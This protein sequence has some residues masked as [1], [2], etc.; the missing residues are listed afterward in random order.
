MYRWEEDT[1]LSRNDTKRP[2]TKR[3]EGKE[4]ETVFSGICK[5]EL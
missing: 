5:T 3:L 2:I 4:R 1:K